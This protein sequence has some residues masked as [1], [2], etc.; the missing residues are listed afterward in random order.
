M[1]GTDVPRKH[2]QNGPALKPAE[3]PGIVLMHMQ[4]TLHKAVLKAAAGAA[5]LIQGC[6]ILCLL[7]SLK[8]AQVLHSDG[9]Q[10]TPRLAVAKYYNAVV[11]DPNG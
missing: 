2:Q 10:T 6:M 1:Q 9:R 4:L 8:E 3:G 5:D 11:A 7:T